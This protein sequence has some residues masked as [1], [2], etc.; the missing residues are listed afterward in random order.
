MPRSD[1]KVLTPRSVRQ[2]RHD[3]VLQFAGYEVRPDERRSVSMLER[4]CRKVSHQGEGVR[5]SPGETYLWFARNDPS[6]G[7]DGTFTPEF[8][9]GYDVCY[10][11]SSRIMHLRPVVCP[12]S[13]QEYKR[14]RHFNR[15]P[16]PE[17]KEARPGGRSFVI[18]KHD[19]THLHYDF[20]LEMDG[21]LKSWAVPKGPSLDPSVSAWQCTSKT[22]RS[23]TAPL[24]GSSPRGIWRR[25]RD[26]LGSREPGSRSAMR[27]KPMERAD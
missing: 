3:R 7:A 19:A 10:S 27:R 21:V 4:S 17:G 18:Q 2:F 5:K 22:T 25:H 15:T 1:V 16:E 23:N 6:R 24:R 13:L 12:M 26:A 20:R 14:K 8:W 11:A 9:L